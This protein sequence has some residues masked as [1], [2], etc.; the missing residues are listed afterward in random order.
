MLR[1]DDASPFVE[2]NA[3]AAETLFHDVGAFEVAL[4]GQ[5]SESIYDAMTRQVRTGG[6]IQSPSDRSGRASNSQEFGDVTIR[7][8][9]PIRNL[10]DDVPN[11]LK[12]I[13]LCIHAAW[14]ATAKARDVRSR[15]GNSLA[16][17]LSSPEPSGKY[18]RSALDP[19]CVATKLE[20]ALY[21]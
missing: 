19:D 21:G 9:S 2:R 3:L 4:P 14:V 16:P 8:D 1:Q 6:R 11:T 20:G 5:G 15:A 7:R 12:K 17:G 10:G 13:V 18:V